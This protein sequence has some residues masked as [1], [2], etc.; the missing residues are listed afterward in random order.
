MHCTLITSSHVSY[1]ID[2]SVRSAAERVEDAVAGGRKFVTLPLSLS[3][4]GLNKAT[5]RIDTIDRIEGS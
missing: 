4:S 3:P 2:L 5:L 1:R